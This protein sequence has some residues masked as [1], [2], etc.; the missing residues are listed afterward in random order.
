MRRRR[1][2]VPRREAEQGRRFF[3]LMRVAKVTGKERVQKK[4]KYEKANKT[5]EDRPR[6]DPS[7]R[8]A[9]WKEGLFRNT[10]VEGG[11]GG[12]PRRHPV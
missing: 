11:S 2:D 8:V 5:Q 4:G 10:K 9:A 6:P 12:G 3:S 7:G 1:R